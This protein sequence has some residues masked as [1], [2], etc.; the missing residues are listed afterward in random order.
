MAIDTRTVIQD[1]VPYKVFLFTPIDPVRP[2]NPDPEP[3]YVNPV[4]SFRSNPLDPTGALDPRG[5]PPEPEGPQP[6]ESF[7]NTKAVL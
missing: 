7:P 6:D 1:T 2:P 4:A 3:S 5:Q